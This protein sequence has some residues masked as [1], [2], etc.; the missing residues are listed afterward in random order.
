MWPFGIRERKKSVCLQI[1]NVLLLPLKW[2]TIPYRTK[3]LKHNLNIV[4]INGSAGFV[5][6]RVLPYTHNIKSI[7]PL[8]IQ[9]PLSRFLSSPPSLTVSHSFAHTLTHSHTH[10]ACV[11][12]SLIPLLSAYTFIYPILPYPPFLN[13]AI[14]PAHSL[15]IVAVMRFYR[16]CER[17]KLSQPCLLNS[18]PLPPHLSLPC[19]PP[20]FPPCLRSP[21]PSPAPPFPASL[22]P[23][24]PVFVLPCFP[25]PLRFLPSPSPNFPE[26]LP[27]PSLLCLRPPLPSSCS[28]ISRITSSGGVH[29]GRAQ[30]WVLYTMGGPY[31]ICIWSF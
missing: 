2:N 24:F 1:W 9:F 31:L 21:L 19:L 30:P 28:T 14:H 25:V 26:F 10:Y 23:P 22:L 6:S 16:Q 18:D 11:V 29:E 20:S 8:S 13:P 15:I 7:S 12:S 17:D 5:F 27:L 4:E 3:A